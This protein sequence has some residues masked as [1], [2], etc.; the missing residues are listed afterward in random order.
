M[1]PC[2]GIIPARYAS[3]RFPGKPLVEILGKPMFW[4]VWARASRCPELRTVVLATDDE[5]IEAAAKKHGVPVVMT[6]SDHVSGT[7]RVNEA[8]ALLGVEEEAVVVNIQGDEPALDPAMLSHLV[9]PF[10]DEAV[11]AATLAHAIDAERAAVPD[12]VKVVFT[13]RRD[14]LYFSRAAVPHPRNADGAGF[15]GHI[16]MYAFRRSTLARFTTLPQGELEKRESL[17]QL[18]LL[19]ND[20]PIRVVLVETGT[21]GVDRPEDLAAVTALLSEHHRE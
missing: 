4:H 12:Q 13:V 20:I 11:R 2:Y 15:F 8:A 7:D 18:R 21:R 3:T 10:A 16:G 17:E 6:R 9:A 14:A 5:R 1:P 19:E